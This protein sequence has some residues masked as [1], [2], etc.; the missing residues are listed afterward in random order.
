MKIQKIT[1]ETINMAKK[2]AEHTFLPMRFIIEQTIQQHFMMLLKNGI[3][4]INL[5]HMGLDYV[6]LLH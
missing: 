1:D 4:I 2:Y 5:Y 3:E 6:C